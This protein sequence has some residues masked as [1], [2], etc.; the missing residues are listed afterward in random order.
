MNH[1]GGPPEDKA[2]RKISNLRTE[3]TLKNCEINFLS[4][5]RE[6]KE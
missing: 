4:N 5:A 1:P 2:N 6:I 3:L